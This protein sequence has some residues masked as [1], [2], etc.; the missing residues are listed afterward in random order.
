MNLKTLK[1]YCRQV[2]SFRIKLSDLPFVIQGIAIALLFGRLFFDSW[3]AFLLISPITVPWVIMQKKIDKKQKCM[4]LGIQFRDAIFSVL[5]NLKAGYSV[6][7]AFFEAN[8]DMK[9]LYGK[10]KDISDYLTMINTG[11]KNNIPLEKL[12]YRMGNDSENVDI[13]EFAF[14]FAAS[15]RSGGNMTDIIE[16][17]INII[18]RKLEVEKEIDVLVSAKRLEARIMNLVPF[19]IIFYIS[20]TSPGF[21]DVLYHNPFGIAVMT[22]CMVLYIYNLGKDSKYCSVNEYSG[23]FISCYTGDCLYSCGYDKRNR[24]S[25]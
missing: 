2:T 4:L 14:V 5:T 24:T 9:L 17:T 7:N 18:S 11:L 16:R 1:S 10:N 22:I 23:V 8:K 13:Q 12:I 20:L 21:F 3:I 19:F 6:E 15:K 25:G